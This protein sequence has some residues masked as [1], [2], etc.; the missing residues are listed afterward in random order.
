MEQKVYLTLSIRHYKQ[1]ERH[2]KIYINDYF[3][4]NKFSKHAVFSYTHNLATTKE[5]MDKE[6]FDIILLDL[7]LED[8]I[9]PPGLKLIKDYAKK[10]KAKIIVVSAYDEYEKDC[11]ALGAVEFFKKPCDMPDII[12]GFKRCA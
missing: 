12:E 6:E 11:M 8:Y 10:I 1:I 3:K 7:G 4:Y 5:A 9:P 2:K